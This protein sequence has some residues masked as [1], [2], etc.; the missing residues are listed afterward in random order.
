MEQHTAAKIN[1][2]RTLELLNVPIDATMD[3]LDFH[4][5]CAGIAKV[6]LLLGT[7][8]NDAGNYSEA[9]RWYKACLKNASQPKISRAEALL[10]L[11][12][13]QYKLGLFS[14]A[15]NS[16]EESISI[17]Q[18]HRKRGGP[19][20]LDL[21]QQYK[22]KTV[23]AVRALAILKSDTGSPKDAMDLLLSAIQAQNSQE[24]TTKEYCE[25]ALTCAHMSTVVWRL[26]N[27][28]EAKAWSYKA[29]EL[30]NKKE[31][32]KQIECQRCEALANTNLGLMAKVNS[33]L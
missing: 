32:K 24:I 15:E 25:L 27:S 10:R 14:N 7:I 23:R 26:G 13:V 2:I 1:L 31:S 11:G 33:T 12:E 8:S 5:K 29:L 9:M 16:L 20:G 28:Q 4:P 30:A 21:P 22:S 19:I 18:P 17:S 3:S 6:M